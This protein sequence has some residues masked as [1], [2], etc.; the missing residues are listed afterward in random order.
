MASQ[1]EIINLALMKLGQSVAIPNLQ[2]KSKA[3]AVMGRLWD[4][5]VALALGDR[6]WPFAM[7]SVDLARDAQ[8]PDPG[9]GYRYAL[10][11]GS[12]RA[13]AIISRSMV[14][15]GVRY[16][17]LTTTDQVA[18]VLGA[19][20][21][22]WELSHGAQQTTIN[23]NVADAVLVYQGEVGDVSRFSPHFI[24]AV[25]CRLALDA[26]PALIGEVGLNSQGSLLD[27]YKLALTEAG[28]IAANQS[29]GDETYVTP[30]IR[31]RGGY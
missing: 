11:A 6:N 20:A 16:S 12:V 30:S 29:R 3:A 28:S 22:S 4:H 5:S 24:E 2:D 27:R 13:I 23:A 14:G 25:A 21:L 15:H 7:R 26:A 10:P 17:Q 19:G 8:P 9:W 1:T 18:A 31:A